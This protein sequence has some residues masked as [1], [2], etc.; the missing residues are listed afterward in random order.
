MLV[1]TP[2]N[3]VGEPLIPGIEPFCSKVR[4]P[5]T[6]A[7]AFC[8][9]VRVPSAIALIQNNNVGAKRAIVNFF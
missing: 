5:S 3:L 1:I 8:S 2:L 4:V 9:K 6:I 7:E